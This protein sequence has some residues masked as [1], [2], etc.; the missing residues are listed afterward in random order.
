MSGVATK[1]LI[2][3]GAGFIGTHLAERFCP[4]ARVVLLDNFRRNSLAAAP[5]LARDAHVEVRNG[6]VLDRA[7]LTAA[8]RGT[9]TVCHLAAI[10]GVSS[11]YEEPLTTLRVNVLGTANVI[12]AAVAEGVRRIVYF[13]TSEVFGPDATD[14]TEE[15]PCAIGAPSDRRWVYA[16]SKLAGEHW[17]LRAGEVHGIAASVVRPF[18]VYGPR[19]MGEGAIR[20]FLAAAVRGAPLT[21]YGD[22]SAVRAWCYVGDLVDAVVAMLESSA[23]AG[24]VFNVGNPGAVETTLGLARRIARLVPDADIRFERGD[25]AEVR[26]RIPGVDKA[27]QRLGW[28]PKVDLDEGLRRT[29]AWTRQSEAAR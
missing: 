23:A 8:M 14:V 26:S 21:V 12:E 1:I 17:V 24:Q 9:D 18:N 3:G 4:E 22:G 10:A 5:G 27:R 20:N 29:L 2:T 7:S 25:R 28:A 16:T 15:S 11:Y 13:S 19:Q 6:D